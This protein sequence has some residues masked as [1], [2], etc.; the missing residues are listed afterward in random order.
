MHAY[1]TVLSAPGGYC[2]SML[3]PERSYTPKPEGHMDP[4]DSLKGML[5]Y[6]RWL[7]TAARAMPHC[8]RAMSVM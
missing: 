7:R 8:Y 5:C 1:L 6:V 2:A 4:T 3:P